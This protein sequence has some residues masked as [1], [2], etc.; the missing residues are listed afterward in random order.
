MCVRVQSSPVVLIMKWRRC[1]MAF[2]GSVPYSV[3]E[4]DL[5]KTP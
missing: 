1:S 3:R 4:L 5:G 2:P